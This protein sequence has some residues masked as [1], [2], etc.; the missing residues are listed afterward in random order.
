MK[1]EGI[2]KGKKK[3]RKEER[4]EGGNKEGGRKMEKGRKE[5]RV[6]DGRINREGEQMGGREKDDMSFFFVLGWGYT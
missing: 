3:Q 6:E 1:E 4:K 2:K 5:V